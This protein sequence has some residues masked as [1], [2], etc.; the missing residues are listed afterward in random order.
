MEICLSSEQVAL[1]P[2]INVV[3]RRAVQGLRG[4]NSIC[5]VRIR[6]PAISVGRNRTAVWCHYTFDTNKF[7]DGYDITVRLYFTTKI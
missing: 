7:A 3:N 2:E 4:M 6:V 5:V 1:C